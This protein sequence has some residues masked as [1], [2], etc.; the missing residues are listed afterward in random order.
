MSRNKKIVVYSVVIIALAFSYLRLLDKY[1][2]PEKAFYASEKGLHYGTSYDIPIKYSLDDDRY[3]MIG[4][5]DYGIYFNEVKRTMLFLWETKNIRYG[6]NIL[7]NDMEYNLYVTINTYGSY[8][9][10]FVWGYSKNKDVKTIRCNIEGSDNEYITGEVSESGIFFIPIG[11][12]FE[13][14]IKIFEGLDV[15]GNVIEEFEF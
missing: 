9:K 3:I 2:T 11:G 6:E 15:N 12:A 8:D 14:T 4:K 10:S 7:F 13:H 1:I 5:N